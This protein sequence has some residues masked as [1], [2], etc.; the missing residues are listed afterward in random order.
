MHTNVFASNLRLPTPERQQG[1][2]D[3]SVAQLLSGILLAAGVAAQ[4]LP[5]SGMAF[6]PARWSVGQRYRCE[7]TAIRFNGFAFTQTHTISYIVSPTVATRPGG[8]HPVP[9]LSL[10]DRHPVSGRA[11][12]LDARHR[13]HRRAALRAPLR[14][15]VDLSDA[16]GPDGVRPAGLAGRLDRHAGHDGR[17]RRLR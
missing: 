4:F 7:I 11:E 2:A 1:Y 14:Q 5:L 15:M 16:L 12:L 10:A 8:G 13:A 17:S 3:A 6:P 9:D